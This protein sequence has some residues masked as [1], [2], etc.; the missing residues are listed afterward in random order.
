MGVVEIVGLVAQRIERRALGGVEGA[1][2]R[3]RAGRRVEPGDARIGGA[4]ADV[5]GDARLLVGERR[6]RKRDRGD[7]LRR[8]VGP[9]IVGER[10]R[11]RLVVDAGDDRAER[12][13]TGAGG[14]A[15]RQRAVGT[16]QRA[17]GLAVLGEL[18]EPRRQRPAVDRR[19]AERDSAEDRRIDVVERA[20]L[21]RRRRRSR[22][23]ASRRAR[24]CLWRPARSAAN[25]RRS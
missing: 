24:A 13:E 7:R 22:A 25:A 3:R 14:A 11:R 18:A 15:R 9:R 4:G 23:S 17:R 5:T 12:V 6:R 20:V 1:R 2:P 10:L 19:V 8:A 21:G 16:E